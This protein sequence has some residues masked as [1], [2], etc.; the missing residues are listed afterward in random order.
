MK[1]KS[2]LDMLDVVVGSIAAL[3]MALGVFIYLSY[4]E[5]QWQTVNIAANFGPYMVYVGI[6]YVAYRVWRA[7]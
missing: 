4:P 7:Q 5:V 6:A 3:C 1:D 2:Q